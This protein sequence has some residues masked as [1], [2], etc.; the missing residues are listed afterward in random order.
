M[1]CRGLLAASRSDGGSACLALP[2]STSVELLRAYAVFGGIPAVLRLL[3]RSV[4]TETNARRLMLDD[5]GPL[6]D[7][8]GMWLERDLQTP[9]RYHAILAALAAGESDWATVHAGVS[10]L[11]TSGQVAPYLRRLE[12]LGL[13]E[14][15][16][17]LDAR[18]GSRGRRYRIVDPLF[19]FWYRYV[20]PSRHGPLRPSSADGLVRSIRARFDEHIATIFPHICRQHAEYDAIETLG[21]N[22]R[23]VGGLWATSYDLPV[24]GVLGS[25]AVFYGSCHWSPLVRGDDPLAKLDAQIRETRYGFGRQQRLRVL[26]TRD[27]APRW[28]QRE[29]AKRPDAQILTAGDLVGGD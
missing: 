10:D 8:G 25:G 5:R 7:V 15:R 22:A 24:A 4:T 13:I 20:L 12:Q 1:P 26:F 27:P 18:S 2:G 14:T 23:E 28:L 17:S 6:A 11:T 21:S 3:D 16:Q 29:I 9:N 19:A